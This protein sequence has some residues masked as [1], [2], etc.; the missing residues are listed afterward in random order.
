VE[1]CGVAFQRKKAAEIGVNAP[2]PGFVEPALAT[3]SDKVP[4][5][6]RWIHEIKFDGCRVQLHI[7]NDAIK[8]LTRRGN[9]WTMRFSKIAADAYLINAG[10]AII[11]GEVVVPA[12]D[13]TTDFSVLQNELRGKSNR[14]VMIAFDLLYLNGYDLRSLPLIERKALLKKTIDGT[15]LQFSESFEVDGKEMFEHACKVGLEGVV[16]KVRDSRYPSDRG[17][18][19]AKKTCAQRETLTI[20]GFSRRQRLGRHLCR[21]PQ[22]Q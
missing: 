8:V 9:D 13:G 1:F 2:F 21:P 7:H 16:S 11:D 6:D 19:W 10:S 22:G 12:A 18:D 20:G 14:L 15:D 5:G 4:S 17:R 3:S